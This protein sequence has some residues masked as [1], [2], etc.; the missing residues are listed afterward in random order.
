MRSPLANV[1]ETVTGAEKP[2][3]LF[4]RYVKPSLAGVPVVWV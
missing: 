1:S 4:A 3:A 2:F